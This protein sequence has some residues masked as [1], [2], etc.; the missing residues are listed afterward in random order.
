MFNG[1]FTL[2]AALLAA[3]LM[4]G[5]SLMYYSDSEDSP[6]GDPSV[7]SGGSGSISDD[8]PAVPEA[9]FRDTVT[10]SEERLMEIRKGM[11]CS[12]VVGILG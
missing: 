10:V 3:V 6:G 11:T 5:C 4:S 12:E 7:S 8:L 2:L 1:K 9:L